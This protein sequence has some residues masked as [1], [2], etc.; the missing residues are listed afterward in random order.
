MYF[1]YFSRAERYKR[2]HR[3]QRL[4]KTILKHPGPAMGPTPTPIPPGQPLGHNLGS[5]K[6]CDLAAAAAEF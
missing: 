3:A 1:S 5:P 4:G 6:V 2:V